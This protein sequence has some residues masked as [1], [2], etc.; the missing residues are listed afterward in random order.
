MLDPEAKERLVEQFRACLDGDADDAVDEGEA[1]DL[2]TLLAEMAALKNEVRL[3]ARQFKSALEQTQ[4]LSDALAEHNQA[5][6]RDLERARAQA[7]EA[8]AQAERGLLLGLLELRDRLQAGLDAQMAWRPSPLLRL[9]G[10]GERHARSLREGSALTLQ[11]LDELL[12]SHRVRPIAA[13]GQA[14]DPQCMQAVGIEWAPQAAEGV[15]LR[16]LRRGF[17]QGTV[18]LRTAEVIVNKKGPV[19]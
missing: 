19:P 7:A 18:L 2:S 16:E 1:I 9:L 12:A 10:D 14:L 3:Q 11:R 13:L 17:Q 4:A 15:V 8:K 5:L 6:A